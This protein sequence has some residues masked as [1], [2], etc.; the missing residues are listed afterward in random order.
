MRRQARRHRS[1]TL[2]DVARLAGVSS[3]TVSRVL[4][5]RQGVL[6][7]TR[8][9]VQGAMDE[10]GYRPNK[11]AQGLVHGRSQTIGVI[12]TDTAHYGPASTL[13]GI[14]EA[15][16]ARGYAVLIAATPSP[17]AQGLR[18][19]VAGLHERAVDSIVAIAPLA[20]MTGG[21]Q[22]VNTVVPLAL[23]EAGSPSDAPVAAIDQSAGARLATT[24]LLDLGHATVHHLAGPD[25]WIEARQRVAG[26]RET[27]IERGAFV[28][29]VLR[30]D[31][32]PRSGFDAALHL[33]SDAT[34]VF[35]ANDQMAMGLIAALAEQGCRVPQD[36]SVVGFDDIPEAAYVVPGLTTISQ[37]FRLLGSTV[38]SLLDEILIQADPQ[39]PPPSERLI[40]PSL[41]VR[42][43]TAP[44]PFAS[45]L[46]PPHPISPPARTSQ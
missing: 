25:S 41:I 1:A 24:H 40:S 5:A 18:E 27:L 16:R 3:M 6:P 13:L 46:L 42:R 20:S 31:W 12:V 33:P 28:P 15:A 10:L 44:P 37:N 11:L 17:T 43:S 34:C 32:S 14:E 23:A 35:A 9:R 45:S 29:G 30:G 4:N 26:W 38:L 8:R 2:A 36:I 19:A 22:G 39:Q 21:L 7:E